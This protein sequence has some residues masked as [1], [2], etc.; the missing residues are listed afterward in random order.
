MWPLTDAPLHSARHV[1]P[2][3]RSALRTCGVDSDYQVPI[4]KAPLHE[5]RSHCVFRSRSPEPLP[6]A[7]REVMRCTIDGDGKRPR[8]ITTVIGDEKEEILLEI[9]ENFGHS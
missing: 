5:G 3:G 4:T 1:D 8:H 2:Q 9:S 6:A 7:K